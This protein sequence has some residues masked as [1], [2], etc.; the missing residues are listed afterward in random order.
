MMEAAKLAFGLLL[1]AY[2]ICSA[3][4]LFGFADVRHAAAKALTA[5]PRSTVSLLD[6]LDHR[7][8]EIERRLA[9]CGRTP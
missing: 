5:P 3:L 2:V 7:L 8:S 6:G 1:A 9:D 4:V